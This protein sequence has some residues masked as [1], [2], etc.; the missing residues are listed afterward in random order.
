[1]AGRG[2]GRGQGPKRK[3]AKGG[4]TCVAHMLQNVLSEK[5]LDH[6]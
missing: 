4:V 1:M 3:R 5:A 6:A 2:R